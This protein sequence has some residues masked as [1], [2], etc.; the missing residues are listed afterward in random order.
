MKNI[1]NKLELSIYGYD[2]SQFMP[3]RDM[4]GRLLNKN[5]FIA[6]KAKRFVST[7]GYVAERIAE[8]ARSK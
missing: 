6:Y 4:D 3:I 7:I 8:N 1:A 5:K 2:P